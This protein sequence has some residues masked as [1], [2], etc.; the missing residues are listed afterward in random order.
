MS[1]LSVFLWF[2][3]KFAVELSLQAA[4][5][6]KLELTAFIAAPPSAENPHCMRSLWGRV[7]NCSLKLPIRV[8][9]TKVVFT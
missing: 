6:P 9:W 5:M 8:T 7:A 2:K 1:L 3:I 4:S